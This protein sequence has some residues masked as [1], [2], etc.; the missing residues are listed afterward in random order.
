MEGT[1]LADECE[2]LLLSL[3]N[4]FHA[5]MTRLDRAVDRIT[6]EMRDLEKAQDG[7]EVK[8][9]ELETLTAGA[10]SPGDRRDAFETMRDVAAEAYRV[11]TGEVWRQR[12]GL[13]SS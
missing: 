10:R 2:A 4:C 6:P 9:H 13:H 11:H 3:V 8:V 5:Q 12:H 7:T 1:Q